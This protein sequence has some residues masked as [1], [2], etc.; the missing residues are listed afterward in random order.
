MIED[1][2]DKDLKKSL[3]GLELVAANQDIMDLHEFMNDPDFS[4]AN[5]LVLKCIANPQPQLATIRQ[6]LLLM[7][8]YAFKF[9]MQ[10]KLYDSLRK[11]RAGTDSNFK[12]NIFYSASEQCHELA[13]TLKYLLRDN[14]AF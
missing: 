7:Q 2:A 13:Q 12:K 10:S 4:L 8:A 9:R 3:G 14:Q 1:K 6:A 5:E 11:G